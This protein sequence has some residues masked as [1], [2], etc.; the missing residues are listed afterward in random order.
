[1]VDLAAAVGL[2]GGVVVEALFLVPAVDEVVGELDEGGAL[3]GGGTCAAEVAAAVS[4]VR[5]GWGSCDP[6]GGWRPFPQG[7]VRAALRSAGSIDRGPTS[8]TTIPAS[9]HARTQL[10]MPPHQMHSAC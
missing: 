2:A 3:V 8:T 5:L 9:R 1:M 6:G 7:G 10:M 4:A